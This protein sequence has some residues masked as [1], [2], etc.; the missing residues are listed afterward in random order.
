MPPR[1]SQKERQKRAKAAETADQRRKRFRT[2]AAQE[3]ERRALNLFVEGKT[4][5]DIAARLGVAY[6][7]A[8]TYVHRGLKR[9]ADQDS[10]IAEK[11]RAFLQLQIEALMGTWMPRAR[12]LAEVDGERIP[13]DPRAADVMIKLIN[14]YAGIT[15]ALSPVRVEGEINTNRPLSPD[16]AVAA[17]MA[18]LQRISDKDKTIEGHLADVGH[19]QHE[20]TTGQRV[21]ALPPPFQEKAA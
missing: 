2:E 20:L 6:S 11:A 5:K 19:N 3:Q 9:R 8:H 4:Y 17:I 15:G 12:G 18:G 7:T 16:E 10:E 21:D 14:Q 1:L 13:P